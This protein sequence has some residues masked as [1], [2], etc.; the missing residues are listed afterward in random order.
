MYLFHNL[1]IFYCFFNIRVAFH[2]C[3]EDSTIPLE[4]CPSD[5][6]H[7]VTPDA[8]AEIEYRHFALDD[9]R[10][11]VYACDR[12][13]DNNQ[14]HCMATDPTRPN[15]WMGKCCSDPWGGKCA[16]VKMKDLV[17]ELFSNFLESL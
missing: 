16:H 9:H 15:S 1:I 11:I 6:V 3:Y 13:P 14:M 2:G 12:R 10:D 5:P 17:S 4:E 7:P 8:S